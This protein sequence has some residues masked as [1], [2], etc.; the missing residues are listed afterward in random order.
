MGCVISKLFLDFYIFFIFT[1]PLRAHDFTLMK[2][3]SKLYVGKYLFSQRTVNEWNKL[4]ADCVHSSSITQ[5][6]PCPQ[7]SEMLLEWQSC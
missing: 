7:P 3:Q 4:S 6:L 5:Q 2:R 1:R